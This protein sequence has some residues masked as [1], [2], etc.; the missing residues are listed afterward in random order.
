MQRFQSP[1]KPFEYRP[2]IYYLI[3][4]VFCMQMHQ[5]GVAGSRVEGGG[6]GGSGGGG[7]GGHFGCM[8]N[9]IPRVIPLVCQGPMVKKASRGCR[10][11]GQGELRGRL[12]GNGLHYQKKTLG[13]L[14][15]L[16]PK[17]LPVPQP[18]CCHFLLPLLCNL[19][20]AKCL[21]WLLAQWKCISPHD[22]ATP[23]PPP[24]NYGSDLCV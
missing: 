19:A 20:C 6:S 9:E 21:L 8:H 12:Q 16:L 17:L 4:S 18:I 2:L 24:A 22:N 23:P 10:K 13:A 7:G 3:W 15:T 1:C 14:L 11:R 5:W